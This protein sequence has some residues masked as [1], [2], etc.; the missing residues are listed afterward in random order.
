MRH[1]SS[2]IGSRADGA[3]PDRIGARRKSER[4][5]CGDRGVDAVVG[6]AGDQG[7]LPNGQS[8]VAIAK[9]ARDLRETAH[10]LDGDLPIGNT[11]PIQLKP[12]CFWA[13]TPTCAM[14][15]TAGRGATASTGARSSLRPSLSS[16]SAMSFSKPQASSTYL[17]R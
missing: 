17:S 14:R 10:L 15:S 9:V 2:N 4:F 5:D 13:C 6:A 3:A 1:R 7:V 16:T 8:N 11:T 12:S